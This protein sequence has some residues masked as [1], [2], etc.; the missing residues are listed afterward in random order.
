MHAFIRIGDATLT[1]I[2][3][4]YPDSPQAHVATMQDTFDTGE[5][6]P[7][8]TQVV[9][10]GDETTACRL[11]EDFMRIDE[12]SEDGPMRKLFPKHCP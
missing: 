10:L 1:I 6:T 2:E 4:H 5:D 11:I 8:S 12:P 7:G 9:L 3:A